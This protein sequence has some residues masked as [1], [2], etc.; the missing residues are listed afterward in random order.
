MNVYPK[1]ITKDGKVEHHLFSVKQDLKLTAK[2]LKVKEQKKKSPADILRRVLPYARKYKFELVVTMFRRFP[3]I[4]KNNKDDPIMTFLAAE[5]EFCNDIL[6][7][8]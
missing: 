2:V 7:F 8:L 6:E 5:P 3:R 1:T 4:I